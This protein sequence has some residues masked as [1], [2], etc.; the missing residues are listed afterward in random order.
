MTIYTVQ[1]APGFMAGKRPVNKEF[2]SERAFNAYLAELKRRGL[3]VEH[4][5]SSIA[6]LPVRAMPTAPEVPTERRKT[7]RLGQSGSGLALH[8]PNLT[9]SPLAARIVNLSRYW[10]ALLLDPVQFDN[11]MHQANVLMDL[12]RLSAEYISAACVDWD[13]VSAQSKARA[14][15]LAERAPKARSGAGTAGR[16]GLTCK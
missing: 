1:N 2:T 12:Q 13:A 10:R 4:V 9:S 11:E 15:V 5:S 16:K 3:P 6:R 7:A 8:V 14:A